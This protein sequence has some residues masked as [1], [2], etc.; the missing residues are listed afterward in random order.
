MLLAGQ[1][2]APWCP[3]TPERLPSGASRAVLRSIARTLLQSLPGEPRKPPHPAAPPG[4]S[5]RRAHARL[6]WA[7]SELRAPVS[8][9]EGRCSAGQHCEADS[10]IAKV[11]RPREPRC[12]EQE[13]EHGP[14]RP[15]R[16]TRLRLQSQPGRRVA[17]PARWCG[18]SFRCRAV[19]CGLCPSSSLRVLCSPGWNHSL[20]L[21]LRPAGP[22]TRRRAPRARPF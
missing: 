14:F 20:P 6:L 4:P 9:P 5:L 18:A 13:H 2:C 16:P 19:L 7:Q 21:P 15:G 12:K 10:P 22:T 1:G 3:A 17:K 8:S 11:R